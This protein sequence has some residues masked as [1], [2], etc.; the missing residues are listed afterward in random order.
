MTFTTRLVLTCAALMSLNTAPLHAARAIDRDMPCPAFEIMGEGPDV[1]LVPGLGSSPEV[2][3]GLRESLAATYR[4]HLVH[5]A[6]FAG[7][8]PAG[9]PADLLERSRAEIIRHL[10]CKGVSSAAYV[11]HSLG[12]FLGL[13]LAAEHPT[14]IERLVVVDSL[15]FFSL[16]FDPAATPERAAPQ[17]EAMRSALLAQ[18]AASFAEGQRT[19]VQSLVRDPAFHERIVEWSLASDR[20]TFA[21]A[22]HKLM[23]TDLRP[24]LAEVKVPVTIMIAANRFAPTTLVEPLYRKAYR[25]LGQAEF[26]VIED[27]Y[28]FIMFDQPES[29]REAL[30]AALDAKRGSQ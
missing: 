17:A 19:G 20:A 10:D 11:G 6:G 29:C 21:G 24:R 1:V 23:T 16:V 26:R 2:W 12:G 25:S 14:R 7:R 22:L 9:D 27:T 8:A 28:H 4:L 30:E 3:S 18:G 5:I 13:T 15:P